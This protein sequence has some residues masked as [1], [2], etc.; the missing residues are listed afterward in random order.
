MVRKTMLR[1]PC[2]APKRCS[3]TAPALAS[4][5]RRQHAPNSFSRMALIGTSIQ[6]GRLG[7][8]WIMPPAASRGPPQLTPIAF[9]DW[10]ATPRAA[11]ES[12]KPST[13]IFSARWAPSSGSVGELNA[14]IDVRWRGR[15]QDRSLRA[16]DIDPGVN[17]I[18]GNCTAHLIS[19]EFGPGTDRHGNASETKHNS[20]TRLLPAAWSLSSMRA[21]V[22]H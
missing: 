21:I 10:L 9:S 1:V 4:F 18:H 11:S 19:R 15:Q 3:A 17:A 20:E 7:G 6:P 5:S 22:S 16:A 2:P 8:D 13:I 14:R 12:R